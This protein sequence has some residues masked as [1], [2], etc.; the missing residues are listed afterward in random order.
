MNNL[1]ECP[2]KK[3]GPKAL[4]INASDLFPVSGGSEKSRL[5]RILP[6]L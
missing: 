6:R 1:D 5:D 3:Q 4:Q 2:K